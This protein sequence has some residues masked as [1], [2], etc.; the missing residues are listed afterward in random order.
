M[1]DFFTLKCYYFIQIIYVRLLT[2]KAP[3]DGG[4]YSLRKPKEK[5]KLFVDQHTHWQSVKTGI[6]ASFPEKKN[7]NEIYI[8]CV[9]VLWIY[10][11]HDPHDYGGLEVLTSA[12]WVGNLETLETNDIDSFR[13]Q[14]PENQK[15]QWCSSNQ[16]VGR[17][18]NQNAPVFNFESEAGKSR[19]PSLMEVT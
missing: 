12:E 10:I 2:L 13:V 6:L 7:W 18:E 9:C 17:L 11:Y 8:M 5:A 4:E 3:R 14:M 1:Q 16:K 15:S 19:C